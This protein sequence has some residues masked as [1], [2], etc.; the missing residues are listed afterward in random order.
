L[1]GR[2]AH[3]LD[4]VSVP[5]Y[6]PRAK[7]EIVRGYASPPR[8]PASWTSTRPGELAGPG[9][10][11][12]AQLGSQG[13]DQGYALRLARQFEGALNLGDGEHEQD[14]ISGC[15]AVALKRASLF[16]RAPVVHDLRLAFTLFGFLGDPPAELVALRA[17]LFEEVANP[18]HYRERHLIVDL[19]PEATLRLAPQDVASRVRSGWRT[20]LAEVAAPE[21]VAA[22][23]EGEAPADEVGVVPLAEPAAADHTVEADEQAVRSAELAAAVADE[24][25]DESMATD[26]TSPAEASPELDE[27]LRS[28]VELEPDELVAP[29]PAAEP[30]PELVD[31]LVAPPPEEGAPSGAAVDELPADPEPAPSD[32]PPAAPAPSVAELVDEAHSN[33]E[34][35][36]TSSATTSS[37]GAADAAHDPEV[38]SR[39][40]EAA[41][42]SHRTH[43]HE[44]DEP[45]AVD[46]PT[47]EH[48]GTPGTDEPGQPRKKVVKKVVKKVKRVR[49]NPEGPG[50]GSS[51]DP[52]AKPGSKPG[53]SLFGRP[54]PS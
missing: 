28:P 18:H 33:T 46:E 11:R 38:R 10:P 22:V 37:S 4:V 2:R 21:P 24:A 42:R 30:T 5:S 27:Q 7:A 45:A 48:G 29:E 26:A 41:A 13:P 31:D 14:A 1:P 6:V 15:M 54:P 50:S 49:K 39:A 35:A 8:R 20:L 47:A 40:L 17:P 53:G 34:P 32:G 9:Q 52:Q 36:G 44:T 25:T 16:G 51:G 23:L 43:G 12:G 19:V 3:T